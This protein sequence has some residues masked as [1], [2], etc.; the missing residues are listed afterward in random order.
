MR[1]VVKKG[2]VKA[3]DLV[4]SFDDLAQEIVKYNK[5]HTAA[6]E[7]E[8]G[9]R[10]YENASQVVQEI[11]PEYNY[12]EKLMGT[13]YLQ[14]GQYSQ[15]IIH[16]SRCLESDYNE[17]NI[18]LLPGN[19]HG[20]LA[21]CEYKLGN[22]EHAVRHCERARKLLPRYLDFPYLQELEE[23]EVFQS[24]KFMDQCGL[25]YYFVEEI[26]DNINQGKKAANF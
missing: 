16:L 25:S 22:I 1:L 3:A 26:M 5:V 18:S 20:M 10:S 11:L 6:I 13:H 17:E 15:A 8:H 23:R 2:E 19:I 9:R 4:E 21:I 24:R 14:Q 12:V 7:L